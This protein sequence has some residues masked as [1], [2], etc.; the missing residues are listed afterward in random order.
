MPLQGAALG[1]A[2]DLNKLIHL[3]WI[4]ERTEGMQVFFDDGLV[5][6]DSGLPTDTFNIVCRSRLPAATCSERMRS[7]SC[8]KPRA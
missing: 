2:D 5:V 1:T 3:S 6:V 4:Q 7:R 8:T